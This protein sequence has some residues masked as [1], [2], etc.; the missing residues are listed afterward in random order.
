MTHEAMPFPE[1]Y[2][3]LIAECRARHPGFIR[4]A[5]P[6]HL[7]ASVPPWTDTDVEV[8]RGD[9]LTVLAAGRVFWSRDA[10]LSVG[11]RQVLWGRIGDADIFRLGSDTRTLTA[12]DDGPLRL[13]SYHGGTW[14]SLKGT[15]V[16]PREAYAGLTGAIDALVIRWGDVSPAQGLEALAALA[17]S[18]PLIAAELAR[19]A[20]PRELPAGFEPLWFVGQ[21]DIFFRSELDRAPTIALRAEANAGIVRRPL[22]L[23]LRPGTFLEWTWRLDA[24]A[25]RVREDA[26]AT[27]DYASI[28]LEFDDGRDLTWYWSAA[29]PEEHHYGCPLP[30]WVG[31]ETHVVVR[32]GRDGLGTWIDHR[33]DVHADVTAALG[34]VPSRIVAVWL[35]AVSLFQRGTASADFRRITLLQDGQAH[36]IFPE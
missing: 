27:H 33:R 11:P 12:T 7:P 21:C 23:A 10:D 3:A 32:S 16:T 34:H 36:R 26:V 30:R 9:A 24:L 6:V 19:L 1:R 31:R 22:D 8:A 2:A 29:L 4:D 17:P 18:D 25:S 14:A 20:S 15:L 35:I 5:R 28:A 13:C